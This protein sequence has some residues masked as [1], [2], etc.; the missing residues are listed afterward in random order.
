MEE[1]DSTLNQIRRVVPAGFPE[2]NSGG[3]SDYPGNKLDYSLN[4]PEELKLHPFEVYGAGF[5]SSAL[6]SIF[7]YVRRGWIF[8][9]ESNLTLTAAITDIDSKMTLTSG[10][11]VWLEMTFNFAG[12]ITAGPILKHGASW[13]NSMYT[14][15]AGV[16]NIWRQPIAYVRAVFTGK[17]TVNSMPNA[18]FP[19]EGDFPD[20]KPSLRIDQL[21]NT[22]LQKARKM[23][24]AGALIWGLVPNWA[25]TAGTGPTG[26]TRP[27]GASGF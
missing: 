20:L 24:S 9:D 25:W 15:T 3:S 23:D 18:P 2:P 8:L 5:T 26:P 1:L 17:S 4:I 27:T 6:T 21:T 12:T 13:G 11:W 14:N 10:D 19:D 7:A 22:H 16:S